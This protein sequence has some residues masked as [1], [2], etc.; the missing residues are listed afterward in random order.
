MIGTRKVLALIPARGG[1]KG[2]TD[3]NLLQVNGRPLLAWT[4]DAARGAQSVDRVVLSSDDERIIAAARAHGCDVPFRRP[5]EL[6]TDQATS[7]DVV[8]HALDALPGHDVVVLLQ[9][10]SPLRTAADIDAA[11]R[12]FETSSAPACVSVCTVEQSPYWM[13]RMDDQGR[14][15]PLIDTRA[16]LA[17][18]QDLPPV[19]IPNGAVYIADV[20]WLRASRTFLSPQ[21]V[22]YVMPTGRSLDIDTADDFAAF[23]R[24]VKAGSGA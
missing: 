4:I 10:T 24:C 17:R 6:A 1:S 16:R 11:C 5:A 7:I 23:E 20:S 15:S 19:F 3:K 13:Y 12:I 9:P 22:A 14:L 2:L 21:T 18:R 8:L